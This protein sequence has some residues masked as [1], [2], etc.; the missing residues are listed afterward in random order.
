MGKVSSSE[1][2]LQWCSY[3]FKNSAQSPVNPILELTVL[4]PRYGSS[5]L[6][7]MLSTW[8]SF[9]ISRSVFCGALALEVTL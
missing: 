5:V 2:V 7:G 8:T 1:Y 6:T 4:L 3:S 9:S